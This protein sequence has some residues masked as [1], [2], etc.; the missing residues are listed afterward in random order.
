MAKVRI[1]VWIQRECISASAITKCSE[2]KGKVPLGGDQRKAHC[3]DSSS[4]C[5]AFPTHGPEREGSPQ[6]GGR[7]EEESES[8][9]D[10]A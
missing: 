4:S 2:G 10:E 1:K 7:K 5:W 8:G 9:L 3:N 6:C